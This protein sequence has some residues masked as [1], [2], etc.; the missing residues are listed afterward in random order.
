MQPD[1]NAVSVIGREQTELSYGSIIRCHGRRLHLS[2]RN[3]SIT[4]STFFLFLQH[5]RSVMHKQKCIELTDSQRAGASVALLIQIGLFTTS[6]SPGAHS[7][8][9]ALPEHD[10]RPRCR[11]NCDAQPN[12]VWPCRLTLEF[13]VVVENNM[14]KH[15]LEL[16]RCEEPSRAGHVRLMG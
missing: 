7:L 10:L 12:V 6:K 1:K 4:R 11:N 8:S 15:G 9:L 3:D 5:V 16:I 2:M 13:D 14:R